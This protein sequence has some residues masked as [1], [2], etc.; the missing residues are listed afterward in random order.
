[1]TAP[2]LAGL[3]F[4]ATSAVPASA[5]TI[6]VPAPCVVN[7]KIF[8]GSPMVVNGAGFGP[9]HSIALETSTGGGFGTT[10][11]GADGSFSTT[12]VA[13]V[14]SVSTPAMSLF[15]LTA[16]DETDGVTTAATTFTAA[17]LSVATH[18]ARARP[19]Q[20]VTYSFS[21]FTRAR[22]I[23]AHYVHKGKVAAT[24]KFGRAAGACG[25]LKHR[26]QLFPGRQRYDHY[27]VQFDDSR[28]YSP[29]SMPRFV[30]T[31][32]RTLV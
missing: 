17:N 11:S 14:L 31:I 5:A 24:T 21:G 25:M 23:Y 22:Q 13:P 10:T 30:S 15:T 9:G 3:A 32:T 6:A 4:C 28:R 29:R 7:A 16:R 27:T 2:A 1:L 26:A 12:I 8:S 18:P 19:S 20:K